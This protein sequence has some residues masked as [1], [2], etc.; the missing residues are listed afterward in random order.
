MH[1]FGR[2]DRWLGAH[3]SI[4]KCV[5]NSISSP[6]LYGAQDFALFLK[7][8]MNWTYKPLAEEHPTLIGTLLEHGHDGRRSLPQ[9]NYP[10]N[11]G[12]SNRRNMPRALT[13]SLITS[14]G[15][16]SQASDFT[17]FTRAVPRRLRQ[18]GRK[19][20]GTSPAASMRF[21]N[22]WRTRG[23]NDK[24]LVGVFR[25]FGLVSADSY[26][27]V[28]AGGPVHGVDFERSVGVRSSVAIVAMVHEQISEGGQGPFLCLRPL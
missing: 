6:R 28:V 4:V 15:V 20:T 26:A 23:Y 24:D 13:A 2:N 3:M 19:H 1:T 5:E 27:L 7:P 22:F 25:W 11:F 8:K 14:G 16:L 12:H 9:G 17:I 21:K 18:G 10:T